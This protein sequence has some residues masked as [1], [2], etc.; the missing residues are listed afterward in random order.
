MAGRLIRTPGLK[1][2]SNQL[3]GGAQGAGSEKAAGGVKSSSVIRLQEEDPAVNESVS[4]TPQV[5]PMTCPV[6]LW[7][8]VLSVNQSMW[9]SCKRS[10]LRRQ[11]PRHHCRQLYFRGRSKQNN[12]IGRWQEQ[13]FVLLVRT[14]P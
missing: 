1:R 6:S 2:T 11:S 13:H 12:G 4:S 5:T 7:P 3:V 8:G 9:A 14:V 10:S